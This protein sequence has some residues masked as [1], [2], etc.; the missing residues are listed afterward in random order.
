MEK[1]KI[2]VVCKKE[3][4]NSTKFCCTTCKN[5]HYNANSYEKQQERGLKRKIKL[6]KIFNGCCCKCGY[7][8]NYAALEFHHK[9]PDDKK[10]QLDLR[11]LSNRSWD[12]I[13]EESKKCELVCS[14]C[15][16]EIHYSWCN[17][18][19]NK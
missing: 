4:N 17:F 7:N 3:T 9:N 14:N 16:R 8:K 5:K 18:D 15:H 11:S 2:C 10:F 13:V 6:V 1:I 12:V 19:K